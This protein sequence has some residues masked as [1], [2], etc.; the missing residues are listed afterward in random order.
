MAAGST[1]DTRSPSRTTQP[2]S[3]PPSATVLPRDARSSLGANLMYVSIAPTGQEVL[4][5]ADEQPVGRPGLDRGP[6]TPTPPWLGWANDRDG[7]E[8]A[9]EEDGGLGHDQVGLEVLPAKGRG[10]EVRKHQP[11]GGV[12]Q[13][14]RIARLVMPGLKMG[15]LGGADTQQDAQHFWMGDPLSQRW[16]EAG[17][18]LLDKT[19][20]EARCVGNRLEVI[21]RVQVGIV[22]GNR[23]KLPCKQPRDGLREGVTEI[24][25]LGAA[26]VAGPPTGVH[27]ELHEVGQPSLVLLCACGLTAPQR[28]KPLQVDGIGTLGDQVGVEEREVA[29]LILGIVVDILVHVPI[30]HFQGSG[31]GGTPAPPW[32]FAVLDASQFVVLLPEIGFEDFGRRQEPENGRVS[33][34]ETATTFFSEGR[35]PIDHEGGADGSCSS[36]RESRA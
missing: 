32:D 36:Y 35:Y 2:L 3:L 16:V 34:C 29:D 26:A 5:L 33:R 13:S 6:C 23:R 17:A 19:K 4:R 18:T 25:I 22:S 30:E 8:L 31:V 11:I 9:A 10:I 28:A 24:G 12:G 21:L 15:C 20:V 7:R 1:R 27:G 14:R